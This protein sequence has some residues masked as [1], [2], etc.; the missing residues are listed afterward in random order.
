MGN[1]EIA[2]MKT[3]VEI[4][5]DLFRQA[6]AEA[7]LNGLKLKDLLA[8]GLRL[9]LAQPPPGKQRRLKFPIIKANGKHT[10]HLPDDI[11]FRVEIA[12]DLKRHEDSV[13]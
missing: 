10:L 4:P 11:A 2:Y 12:D 3:T 13:R 1:W 8:D 6:K 9:R 7:A 5:D